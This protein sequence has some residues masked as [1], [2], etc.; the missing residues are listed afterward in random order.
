ML[1]D[2]KERSLQRKGLDIH[3]SA[4]PAKLR[5]YPTLSKNVFPNPT[6]TIQKIPEEQNLAAPIQDGDHGG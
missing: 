2:S 1:Y 6:Y 4:A 5:L 3:I